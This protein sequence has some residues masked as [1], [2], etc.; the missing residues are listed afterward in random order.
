M[1]TLKV[2]GR[3]LRVSFTSECREFKSISRKSRTGGVG[4]GKCRMEG[5]H[6]ETL[7]GSR[8]P[9]YAQDV[10]GQFL[11]LAGGIRPQQGDDV[12]SRF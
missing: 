1:T 4:L 12:V 7:P 10:V 2:E 6:C 3:Y 5:K 8:I 9:S 11:F